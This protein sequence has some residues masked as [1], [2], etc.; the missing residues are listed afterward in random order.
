MQFFQLLLSE[1]NVSAELQVFGCSFF[2]K[3]SLELK[4]DAKATTII[5]RFSDQY[6]LR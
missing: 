1:N 3:A 4:D 2:E 5:H 6:F